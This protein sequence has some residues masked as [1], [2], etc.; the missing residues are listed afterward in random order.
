MELVNVM[1]PKTMKVEQIDAET[2]KD[3]QDKYLHCSGVLF[4]WSK[5]SLDDIAVEPT[6]EDVVED[7][8]ALRAAYKEAKGKGVPPKYINDAERIKAQL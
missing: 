4:E 3:W 8:K 1:N 2:V 5:L 6:A 7:I